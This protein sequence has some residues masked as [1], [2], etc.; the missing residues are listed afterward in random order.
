MVLIFSFG[1]FHSKSVIMIVLCLDWAKKHF[2]Q[3]LLCFFLKNDTVNF[4]DNY[5]V[6]F[7][8]YQ[9]R[10]FHSKSI[11]LNLLC[12]I[13]TTVYIQQFLLVGL[14]V[15]YSVNIETIFHIF[16]VVICV[17]LNVKY[18]KKCM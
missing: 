6:G 18:L 10:I 2:H 5:F 17:T 15:N 7:S 14:R 1:I 12:L 13:L 8:G 16:L 9:T 4:Q 3:F 11:I